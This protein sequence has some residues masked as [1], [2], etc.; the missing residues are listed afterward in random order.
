MEIKIGVGETAREISVEAEGTHDSVT[1]SVEKAI[2]DNS[3]LS[4]TDDRGRSVL[5][6]ASKIAYVEIGPASSR[7]VG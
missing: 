2:A 3:V 5:V 1:A 6:P 4:L 7:K